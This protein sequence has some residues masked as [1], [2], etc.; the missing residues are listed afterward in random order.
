MHFTRL[1][2]TTVII[3]SLLFI[4]HVSLLVHLAR[5]RAEKA[6]ALRTHVGDVCGTTSHS[7]VTLHPALLLLP[8]NRVAARQMRAGLGLATGRRRRMGKRSPKAQR[9]LNQTL[10]Y[11]RAAESDGVGGRLYLSPRR[12]R[13]EQS[14]WCLYL[15]LE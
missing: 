11:D 4:S 5:S 10:K 6:P 15:S 2:P 14:L 9:M 7:S 12:G 1:K 3:K 13:R 8:T